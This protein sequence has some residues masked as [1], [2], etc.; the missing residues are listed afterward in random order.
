MFMDKF[1][2]AVRRRV[3]VGTL[4][5]STCTYH[6]E[7]TLLLLED[8]SPVSAILLLLNKWSTVATRRRCWRE[9]CMTPATNSIPRT[10][11]PRPSIHP[12]RPCVSGG[13]SLSLSVWF[14]FTSYELFARPLAKQVCFHHQFT[15]HILLLVL[16][17]LSIY[18]LC[19]FFTDSDWITSSA[20]HEVSSQQPQQ[21]QQQTWSLHMWTQTPTGCSFKELLSTIQPHRA[22]FHPSCDDLQE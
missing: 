9:T 8:S 18:I 22:S 19:T 7:T 10:T 3:V 5:V 6:L 14:N 20:C 1:F 21:Q 15:N 12:H 2:L 17:P 16:L 13:E 4:S 11:H